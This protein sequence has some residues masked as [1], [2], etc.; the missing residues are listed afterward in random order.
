[1]LEENPHLC[2]KM[3]EKGRED[4]AFSSGPSLSVSEAL[5]GDASCSVETDNHHRAEKILRNIFKTG[6]GP[7]SIPSTVQS[8]TS[9]CFNQDW[10]MMRA[11]SIVS[12]V[13]SLPSQLLKS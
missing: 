4:P 7:H 13:R 9:R 6:Y 12:H 10:C 2:C 8:I 1:M 3:D 11:G 5:Q